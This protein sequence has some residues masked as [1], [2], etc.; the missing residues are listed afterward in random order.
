[1]SEMRKIQ[2][3]CDTPECHEPV[4]NT[5]QC[6][7]CK[8]DEEEAREAGLGEAWS[9][10]VWNNYQAVSSSGI[11]LSVTAHDKLK[12]YSRLQASA[13][14]TIPQPEPEP[15]TRPH[16]EEEWVEVES[17]DGHRE[18]YQEDSMNTAAPLAAYVQRAKERLDRDFDLVEEVLARHEEVA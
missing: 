9:N 14:A 18:L 15:L 5:G 6:G 12:S 11:P 17:D 13:R 16:D 8:R 2:L 1:M 3:L 4:R 7:R 10:H